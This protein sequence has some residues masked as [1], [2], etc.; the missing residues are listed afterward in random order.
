MKIIKWM[1]IGFLLLMVATGAAAW[2]FA[3]GWLASHHPDKDRWVRR[4]VGKWADELGK[5][6]SHRPLD[7]LKRSLGDLMGWPSGDA[8]AP[9]A[10]TGGNETVGTLGPAYSWVDENG[11][12]HF[13][14][15]PPP[16]GVRDMRIIPPM[17]DFTRPDDAAAP[18]DHGG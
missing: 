11:V 15:K 6:P 12:R 9:E 5:G 1:C 3:S 10:R 13:A 18:S 7:A 4:Q 14:D 16:E 8:D 17:S 2:L